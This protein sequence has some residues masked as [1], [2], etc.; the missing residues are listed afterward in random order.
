MS[1]TSCLGCCVPGSSFTRAEQ[2]GQ[3]PPGPLCGPKGPR[4]RGTLATEG[5]IGWRPCSPADGRWTVT[6]RSVVVG[7]DGSSCSAG[8]ADWTA[9]E[10]ALRRLPLRVVHGSPWSRA[11]LAD[12]WPYRPE[13]LP[14]CP[15]AAITCRCPRL[16]VEAVRLT[17]CPVPALT[18]ETGPCGQRQYRGADVRPDEVA[19]R[20][21]GT[22]AADLLGRSGSA[23]AVPAVSSGQDA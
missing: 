11:D 3:G 8:A 1:N 9:R 22:V 17:G 16:R 15:A 14:G 20:P 10:A 4:P 7:V 13:A 6:T 5:G 19:A 23:V 18:A 21:N 2:M 12:L